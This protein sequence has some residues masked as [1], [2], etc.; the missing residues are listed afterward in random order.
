MLCFIIN[1]DIKKEVQ[2]ATIIY[3][4][5]FPAICMLFDTNNTSTTGIAKYF[6]SFWWNWFDTNIGIEKPLPAVN[7]KHGLIKISLEIIQ[8]SKT[9]SNNRNFFSFHTC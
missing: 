8:K 1:V 4:S 9:E 5:L 2:K 7:A 3:T 6:V